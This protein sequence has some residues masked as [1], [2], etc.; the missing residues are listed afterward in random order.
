MDTITRH[1]IGRR[2]LLL[3]ALALNV[4]AAAATPAIYKAEDGP[5]SVHAVEL[6]TLQDRERGKNLQ[7][8][9]SYPAGPGP[10]PVIVWSHGAGGTKD[11]YAPLVRHWVS[12]GYV[13]IQPNHS[14]SRALTDRQDRT[15]ARFADW[16]NRPR[17]IT[18]VLDSLDEIEAGV[19]A[20]DGMLDH[21]AIGIGGHSFGAHTAQMLAGAVTVQ[22]GGRRVSLEDP[23]PRAFLMLSP[24]GTSSGS[25]GLQ[26]DS[27]DAV[28]RPFMVITGT[29]D[30]GRHGEPWQW[31]VEPF[32]HAPAAQKWLLVI[33]GA[34]HGFG[35]VV[36]TDAF[37]G[38]GPDDPEQ[39]DWVRSA[40]MAF[41][42]AYLKDDKVALNRLRG[43]QLEAAT[44]GRCRQEQATIVEDR[45]NPP[46]AKA[47]PEEPAEPDQMEAPQ[48]VERIFR[49]LD[50]DR[51]RALSQQE[52]P[53]KLKR[54]SRWI[55][56]D[57]DGLLS[58]DEFAD[59]L[60]RRRSQTA[61]DQQTITLH[62]A[63]RDKDL[64]VRVTTPPGDGPFPV[65]LFSHCV[66]GS[67]R[68]FSGLVA[69]WASHGYVVL[70]PDHSDSRLVEVKTG[71]GLDWRNRALDISFVLDSIAEVE[72]RV[73][74][75]RGKLD[76]ERVG[77]GG[78]LIGAYASCICA[79]MKVFTSGPDA[80]PET[81]AD[82]R[83]DAALL[84]SPQGRGQGLTERSW[85]DISVPMLVMAGSDTP[86]RRTQNPPEWR[87]EPFRFSR[88]GD[89]Y[90][91][92]MEGLDNTYA[93]LAGGAVQDRQRAEWVQQ[94]TL[95]FWNAYL[96]DNATALERLNSD[97]IEAESGG[98]VRVTV[99]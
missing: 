2:V 94:T 99:R 34:Y 61:P 38:A 29:M 14:D 6:L 55:D 41:W 87:T 46:P 62:D 84:L 64:Q 67:S 4:A 45:P 16:R 73:P 63:E 1:A 39:C 58:K 60:E 70:Q 65:L 93:G 25:V 24:Q 59:A 76:S 9:I 68:D 7:L 30:F 5:R 18:F 85:E 28:T 77:V 53:E 32:E 22:P 37:R 95:D 80:P 11:M 8:R 42:D 89:K 19:P 52:L 13:C 23:R 35:G 43:E 36:G 21:R 31:R 3:L 83:V 20:L 56:A 17:D 82:E 54:L 98:R 91:V 40:S 12:H 81:L 71:P 10:F 48:R 92:W 57:G 49:L 69:H 88:P 50:R 97:R 44:R 86:S 15:S 27:W 78:H 66:A 33:E 90:L 74:A 79:A 96:K 72:R 47:A 75:V 26:K 51:D